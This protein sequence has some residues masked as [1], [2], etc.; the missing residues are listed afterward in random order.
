MTD[1]QGEGT[2]EQLP[3]DSGGS[4][5]DQFNSTSESLSGSELLK[6]A[7]ENRSEKDKRL[8]A[9]RQASKNGGPTGCAHLPYAFFVKVDSSYKRVHWFRY[10]LMYLVFYPLT[11]FFMMVTVLPMILVL[12]KRTDE[13]DGPFGISPQAFLSWS[14]FIAVVLNV[15]VVAWMDRKRIARLVKSRSSQDA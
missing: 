12:Q 8:R 3:G 15:L 2:E 6:R 1:A 5:G 10:S 11:W 14:F 7:N 9:E 13:P 4:F